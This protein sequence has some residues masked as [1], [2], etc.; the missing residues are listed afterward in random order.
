MFS[1]CT[2]LLLLIEYKCISLPFNI[3]TGD[4]VVLI[5]LRGRGKWERKRKEGREWREEGSN[6]GREGGERE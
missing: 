1:A 6:G 5:R 4:S 3:N 2:L